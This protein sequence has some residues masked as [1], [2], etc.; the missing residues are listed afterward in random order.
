[1]ISD[2]FA[3]FLQLNVSFHYSPQLYFDMSAVWDDLLSS[4]TII[5]S[6]WFWL[7][8][9]SCKFELCR[10]AYLCFCAGKFHSSGISTH[11][12]SPECNCCIPVNQICLP[13]L[14]LSSAHMVPL[15]YWSCIS[16][17]LSKVFSQLGFRGRACKHTLS[18]TKCYMAT[19]VSSSC[20]E[21][22][23]ALELMPVV[24]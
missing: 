24:V 4:L 12:T 11:P 15:N 22:S 13:V 8:T 14:Q 9:P 1:M 10:R 20:A 16:S 18:R 21:E 19:A 2:Y 3:F 6:L 7:V 17:F 5:R 23:F